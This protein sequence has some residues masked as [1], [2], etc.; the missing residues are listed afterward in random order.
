M[1]SKPLACALHH[2]MHLHCITI[3]THPHTHKHICTG[4][5]CFT[6]QRAAQG[7][8][9]PCRAAAGSRA[10]LDAILL[11]AQAVDAVAGPM[12]GTVAASVREDGLVLVYGALVP[13]FAS[14][15]PRVVVAPLI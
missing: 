5:V 10:L 7:E 6:G 12:T 11:H 3:C 15:V 13:P 1:H 4:A 2:H 14:S 8:Q 9:C